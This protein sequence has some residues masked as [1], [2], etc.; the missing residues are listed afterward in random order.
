[1]EERTKSGR[2][3]PGPT[4]AR[5]LMLCAGAF[6]VET[7]YMIE[8]GYAIPAMLATGLP[9]TVASAMWA[10]GPVLGL[11]FQGYLGSASDRCTYS[12][13]KRRPFI[14]AL[15]GCACLATLL[16]P[17]GAFLSGSV[18]RLG[19]KSSSVFVMVF[20]A[21]TFVAM[22]FFLDALQ[23]PLRA[24]LL[25]SVPTERSEQANI[26][27]TAF[28]CTGAISGSL[29]AA[30]PWS[31]STGAGEESD[32]GE[33]AGGGAAN[34][35]RR[36]SRQLEVVY[37]I[38]FVIFV[39]CMLLC[40]NSVREKSPA[41][42][43][44]PSIESV[45]LLPAVVNH[46][47]LD[48]ASAEHGDSCLSLPRTQSRVQLEDLSSQIKPQQAVVTNSDGVHFVPLPSPISR[49]KPRAAPLR[50]SSV[51]GC[52]YGFFSKVY[53]NVCD[54]VLFARHTSPHFTRLCLMLF[55][56]WVTLLS[57]NL[58]FTS[59][60]GQVVY[61]GKPLAPSG[62]EERERFEG[63]VRIGFL[64]F[65]FQDASATASVLSIK[66][67]C[68][69]VGVRRL[70][71]GVLVAYVVACFSAAVWPSLL[72]AVLLQLVAGM[73]YT[74]MQSLP[75]TLLSHYEVYYT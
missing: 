33:T 71:F 10:V 2:A 72:N 5:I 51:R 16:F 14:V 43:H 68:E 44:R 7:A 19:E 48:F 12:W 25:D 73:L 62:E 60:M 40:V 57:I 32:A 23:S 9:E 28:I 61:G 74:N 70:L 37:G 65:L 3:F 26:V 35:A 31:R 47:A 6:A 20:T 55:L 4:Y 18:F 50:S 29:I 8:E 24:Y 42:A 63:G 53:E 22:D 45:T 34:V 46:K 36:S 41:P 69:W 13:G 54:T 30:I 11:V 27:F 75:Y 21:A 49:P 38:A 59:F 39:A 67:L 66:W 52:I 56:S 1:M 17:Y 15:A 58:Y 64:V